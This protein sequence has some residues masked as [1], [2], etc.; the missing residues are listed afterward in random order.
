MS[1]QK[2]NQINTGF[3]Y[4]GCQFVKLKCSMLDWTGDHLDRLA[5]IAH[6]FQAQKILRTPRLETFQG[7]I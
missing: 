7:Q 4:I 3:G 2:Q 1:E 6:L 5:E